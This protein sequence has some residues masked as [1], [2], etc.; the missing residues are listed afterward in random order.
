MT[1]QNVEQVASGLQELNMNIYK[2]HLHR[3]KSIETTKMYLGFLD[4][5]KD[6]FIELSVKINLPTNYCIFNFRIGKVKIVLDFDFNLGRSERTLS[7]P[8]MV[9]LTADELAKELQKIN[10]YIGKPLSVKL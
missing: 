5:P 4:D 10:N 9:G 1:L 3:Q 6:S 2:W 8:F 7:Q